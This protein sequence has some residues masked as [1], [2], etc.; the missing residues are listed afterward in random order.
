MSL[1][2]TS[3]TDPDINKLIKVVPPPLSPSY[4]FPSFTF[5]VTSFT[6]SLVFSLILI[7]SLPLCWYC[8]HHCKTVS[9]VDLIC[10]SSIM[11]NTFILSLYVSVLSLL[12]C[13]GSTMMCDFSSDVC[14]YGVVCIFMSAGPFCLCPLLCL[15]Y[16]S[17]VIL[18]LFPFINR[19][20]CLLFLVISY[21]QSYTSWLPEW[22]H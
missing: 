20:M 4:S 18:I 3:S 19:I 2:F 22:A 7:S 13:I 1:W 15:W 8:Y 10:I 16:H 21:C 5:L 11:Y 14:V 6:V 17:F 12:L 9:A